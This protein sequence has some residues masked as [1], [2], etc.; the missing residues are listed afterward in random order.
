MKISSFHEPDSGTWTHLLADEASGEAAIIDPVWVFDPVSGSA[1]F[2][3]TQ[4]V[5]D[6]AKANGYAVG[7]VLE[8]HA[9]A[10]HLTSADQIRQ[11][12][13]ARIAC[14]RGIRSYYIDRNRSCFLGTARCDR[15]CK[16]I[17]TIEVG[18]WRV[19]NLTISI[20]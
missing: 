14:G 2:S 11:R 18:I 4:K 16:C 13:G 10:D 1:D 6:E 17:N 8:T 9:H 12:V 15:V 5:L 7:W 20:D 19:G 3:F